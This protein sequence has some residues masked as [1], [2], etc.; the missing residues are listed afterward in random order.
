MS[1]EEN[2]PIQKLFLSSKVDLEKKE[3]VP[4][5]NRLSLDDTLKEI[6]KKRVVIFGET[7]TNPHGISLQKLIAE[8][9]S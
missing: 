1:A 4:I 2:E 3:L 6:N 5:A 8:A 9:L 7:I